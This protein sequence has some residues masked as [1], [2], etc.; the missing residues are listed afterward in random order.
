[1]TFLTSAGGVVP[2]A[3][4][5]GFLPWEL[6]V[7]YMAVWIGGPLLIGVFAWI[8]HHKMRHGFPPLIF[9]RKKR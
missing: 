2:T 6:R 7:A 5:I 3:S 1:M 8:A 4:P 9:M